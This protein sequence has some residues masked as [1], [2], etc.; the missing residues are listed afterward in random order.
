MRLEEIRF[1][2]LCGGA[3]LPGDATPATIP[4]DGKPQQK[5]F[6]NRFKYDCLDRQIEILNRQSSAPEN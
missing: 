1:C 4:I 6:H 3:I 2:H 5:F